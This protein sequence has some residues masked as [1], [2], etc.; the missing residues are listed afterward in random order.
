M[1]CLCTHPSRLLQP[2]AFLSTL[3]FFFSSFIIDLCTPFLSL[4]CH[5]PLAICN[6]FEEQ[7]LNLICSFYQL[8]CLF[9]LLILL[10]INASLSIYKVSSSSESL[11]FKMFFLFLSFGFFHSKTSAQNWRSLGCLSFWCFIT[12]LH[13]V[14]TLLCWWCLS[15]SGSPQMK[16]PINETF[17]PI[18]ELLTKHKK[19]QGQTTA[20]LDPQ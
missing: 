7:S 17:V 20:G 4:P 18:N 9:S 6:T 3:Y 2:F 19:I 16:T 8:I 15:K 5:P 12:C 1:T 13:V 11:L 10:S 14:Y